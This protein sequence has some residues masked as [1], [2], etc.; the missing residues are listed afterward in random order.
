[1]I[2]CVSPYIAT[3]GDGQLVPVPCGKCVEC[4]KDWQNDWSFR[5]TQECRQVS[6]PIVVELTFAPE[7][8]PVAYNN[9]AMEWQSY[10]S[11][12]DVQLFLKRLRKICPEFKNNL[13]YFAVGE[14]GGDYNRAHYHVV[15]I[16][17]AIKTVYQYYNKIL[18]AWNQ[19]FIYIKRCQSEQIGYVTKYLNKLDKSSHITSP[20]KL[21]SKHLG[22]CYLTDKMIDYFF[23]TFATGVPF[24]RGY[25]KL[26]RYYRKHLDKISE[27]YG[28]GHYGYDVAGLNYSDV[29]RLKKYDPKG[30]AVYFNDFCDNFQDHFRTIVRDEVHKA[31][32]GGYAVPDLTKLSPNGVFKFFCARVND[33]SLAIYE[34]N[35]IKRNI[36]VKHKF[37]RLT[38]RDLQ[39]VRIQI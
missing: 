6:C 26:P 34:S 20:F 28:T 5:L 22:L 17:S 10:V 39:K 24:K 36:Q 30:L 23:K 31:R 19:G 3:R 21:F 4:L 16:S 32:V 33:I 1:M 9:E 2:M 35:R 38:E 12:R 13:R 15:L 25:I 14:Y 8:L 37:T 11:K 29:I 18:Q 7:Y 27:K